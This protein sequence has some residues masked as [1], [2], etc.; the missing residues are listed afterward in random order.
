MTQV[1][2]FTTFSPTDAS[3]QNPRLL[4]QNSFKSLGL[5]PPNRYEIDLSNEVLNIDFGRGAAKIPEVKSGVR[6]KY[7]STRL[8]QGTWVRT[9]LIGRHVFQSPTLIS[10][11]FAA[12]RPK[13]MFSTSFERSISYLFGD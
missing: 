6:K 8:T 9:G 7:L 5:C 12:S 13:S 4:H 2:L 3:N 11:M 10:N 1:V